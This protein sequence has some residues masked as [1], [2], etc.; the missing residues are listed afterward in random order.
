MKIVCIVQARISSSRLPAKILLPGYDKPL[1]LHLIERLDKS[2]LIND[3]V[4]ATSTN[5]LDDLIYDLCKLKKIKVFRGSL[6][7]LLERYY[8]CAKKFNADHIVRITSDCPLIDPKI[9]DK[10]I[11]KYLRLKNIDF[12]SNT[13][14]PTFPDGF[15]VEIFKFSALQ[16]A[17]KNAK[18]IMKKNMSLHSFGITQKI[19]NC[20]IIN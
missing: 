4:I 2:K 1:L 3:V 10:M 13:H 17:F 19:L 16:K 9:I 20:Q 6:T 5:P 8:K 15:D 14:P 18:K 12:L 11:S 7:N